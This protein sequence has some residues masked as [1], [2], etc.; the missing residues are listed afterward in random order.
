MNEFKLI[1]AGG[2]DFNDYDLLSRVLFAMADVELADK[3]LEIVSPVASGPDDPIHRF[4]A[5]HGIPH[6]L[7]S[8]IDEIGDYGDSLLAFTNDNSL[9]IDP[10][11]LQTQRQGKPV[12]IVN[13]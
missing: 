10:L 12:H 3:Q 9:T 4:V 6:R 2:R 5:E 7:F 1:V 8:N 13:Y 11:I